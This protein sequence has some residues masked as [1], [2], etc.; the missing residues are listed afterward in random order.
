MA[1]WWTSDTHFG[2]SRIIQYCNRPFANHEEMDEEILKRFNE[3]IKPGDELYHLGDLSWSSY[4]LNKFFSRLNTKQ[5]HLIYGNHDTKK[6]KHPNIVS[7]SDIKSVTIDGQTMILCHYPMRSWKN[8]SHGSFQLY[9][10]C[11][12]TLSGIGRQMDIG[13]DTN[14]FYPYSFEQ[15][16]DTLKEKPIYIKEK[17]KIALE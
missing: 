14:N 16:R 7:Y 13:V 2:H 5:V 6:T 17:E 12:G 1:R 3:V 4:D 15:I 8:Q 11:H 10:H 9:G